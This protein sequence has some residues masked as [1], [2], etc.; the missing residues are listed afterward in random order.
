MDEWSMDKLEELNRIED[1]LNRLLNTR[2][3]LRVQFDY[4]EQNPLSL[5][6]DYE[7]IYTLA[8]MMMQMDAE[9]VRPEMQPALRDFLVSVVAIPF[10]Y[11]DILAHPL[12]AKYPFAGNQTHITY[13]PK[14][15]TMWLDAYDCMIDKSLGSG[16]S[17][18]KRTLEWYIDPEK[19]PHPQWLSV[20]QYRASKKYC[21]KTREDAWNH[22]CRL[23]PQVCC[24]G[25]VKLYEK[26]KRYQA[27]KGILIL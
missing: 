24:D 13:L 5:V 7:G 14:I 3:R 18:N 9:P 15:A 23:I 4:W 17:L 6:T 10:D 11:F 8:D 25:G 22:L 1:E 12:R 26:T 21:E 27:D 19:I 20:V 2:A 16:L